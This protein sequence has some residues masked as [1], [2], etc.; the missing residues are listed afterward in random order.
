MNRLKTISGYT[1]A[2]VCFVIVL[3]TFVGQAYFS[4]KLVSATGI[5]VSPRLTG[6]EIVKVIDHGQYKTLIH[7]PVFDGLIWERKNGFI[8]VAW[9]PITGLPPVVVEKIDF[10]RDDKPDFLLTL[11]TRSG[12]CSLTAYNASVLSVDRLYKLEK[13]W[14][15]RVGLR[16]P[17]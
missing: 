12:Q 13:G 11:D 4:R 14:A 6:G 17:S 1:W 16:K 15:V 10:D 7:R 9:E 8:Q 3:A 2:F 5:K